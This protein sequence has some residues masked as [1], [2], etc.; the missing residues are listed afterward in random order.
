METGIASAFS[1][2]ITVRNRREMDGKCRSIRQF[3][4]ADGEKR[5]PVSAY[6]RDKTERRQDVWQDITQWKKTLQ[7]FGC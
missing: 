7:K 3:G 6:E 2:A 4:K 5:D 1:A